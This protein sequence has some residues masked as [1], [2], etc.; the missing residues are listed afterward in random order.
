TDRR[1]ADAERGSQLPLVQA[2]FLLRVIDVGFGDRVLEQCI[3]LIA[4]TR[5]VQRAERERR[6]GCCTLDHFRDG[7]HEAPDAP[8]GSASMTARDVIRPADC[9]FFTTGAPWRTYR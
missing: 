9:N 8:L 4:Q 6:C 2:Q 3:G 1:S 5:R 7:A